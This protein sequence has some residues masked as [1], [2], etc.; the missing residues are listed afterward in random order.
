MRIFGNQLSVRWRAVGFTRPI[1]S[2]WL[3]NQSPFIIRHR[4]NLASIQFSLEYLAE[5]SFLVNFLATSW[6]HKSKTV[7]NNNVLILGCRLEGCCWISLGFFKDFFFSRNVCKT[8]LILPF[9][10][11]SNTSF[12]HLQILSNDP[13]STLISQQCWILHVHVYPGI[14]HKIN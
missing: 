4:T 10:A 1:G 13:T 8:M 11:S 9:I 7:L 12:I 14:V 2:W 3:F 5:R 6:N